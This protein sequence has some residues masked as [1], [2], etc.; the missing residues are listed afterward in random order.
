MKDPDP[1]PRHLPRGLTATVGVV[2]AILGEV[3]AEAEGAALFDAVEGVRRD[4]VAFREAEETSQREAALDRARERLDALSPDGKLALARAY[5]LYLELVNVCEN[6][7]RTHR[8]RERSAPSGGSPAR[9]RLTL[10]LTAHPTESRSPENI[11]LLRRAQ[12]HI[13]ECLAEER[14]LDEDEMK[15]LL[16]VAWRV[17]T[18]ATKKPSV[19]D[20]AHHLFSLLTDPILAELVALRQ[21]GHEVLLR[22]WVGGDKDGHPGVGPAQTEASLNLA[23]ARLL[24]FVAVRLVAP[25]RED[26]EL[27]GGEE[28]TAAFADLERALDALGSVAD[29]DGGRIEALRGAIDRFQSAYRARLG[30]DHPRIAGLFTLLEIFPGLVVPLE[31]REERGRF[32]TG[33]PIAA[34]MRRLGEIAAGGGIDSYARG[35]V[36][37]MACEAEDLLQAQRLAVEVLGEPALPVIP[38]FEL[39]D[40]LERAPDIL[41]EAWRDAAFRGAI[42][43]RGHVEVM[44]GYSDTAKRMGMLASRV[45][46]HDAMRTIVEWAESEDL[47]PHFFHGHG[48]SVGRG[49]GRI[50]DLAATWPPKARAPY[51]YT[52]QGEMVERT[53][54]T[55]EILRSLVEK[56]ASVQEDPPPYSGVGGLAQDL[57]RGSKQAFESVVESEEFR[58]LLREATPYSRLQALTIGSR[59]ASRG[60]EGTR[61][62]GELEQLR[63]IP[64]VL[65]WTQTRLLLHAWLGIGA[66]W[67]RRRDEPDIA[68]RLERAREDPLFRSYA[69]LLSFTLAK[70][71]PDLWRRYR[72]ALAPDASERLVRHLEMEHDAAKDLA[73]RALGADTLLPDRPWLEESIRY[74]APMIHPLNLLQIEL[75]AKPEW[76]EAE[77]R[78]FR[79]T[80]TGIAAGMLTTG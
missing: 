50:E 39:P 62:G 28:V 77:T 17:G 35:I 51:K 34:M 38:L 71:E 16:H 18:H 74:R 60:G 49:G 46:I 64:W 15:N 53:L 29:G 3:V 14:P 72:G 42:R 11:R 45:A 67:S 21:A 30:I 54:A 80:V 1:R 6:A 44:L 73:L 33:E 70:A 78:L 69:R 31:L 65:C 43:G 26:V 22:T 5:T 63:A 10:V 56:V 2:Q 48:G 41:R 4:M 76:N 68:E 40:V 37:S 55:P 58:E 36:V 52:V 7:Y 25:A 12:D 23:R 9:A 24:G 61:G 75:L 8:L 47:V 27:A 57:A 66:A 79:E 20:E 13:V 59:P 32:G 19:E